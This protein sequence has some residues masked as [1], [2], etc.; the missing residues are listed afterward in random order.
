MSLYRVIITI[1]L[2]CVFI[3][4][5][6]QNYQL[7]KVTKAELEQKVHPKDSSAAAAILF[8]KG[9]TYFSYNKDAGFTANHVCEVKIKIYKKEGL[10]WAN[11]KV[12]F[13]IGYEKLNSD[14]LDF[15]DAV[16]YNLENGSIV[17]TKLENQGTFKNKINNYWKEKTITLPNVKVG[18][19]IEYRYVLKSENIVKFPDFDIQ[20]DIPVDYFYYKTELP[21]YYVYKPILVGYIHVDAEAKMVN[22]SQTYDN[23]YGQTAGFTYKQIDSFYSGK[24]IPALKQEPFVDNME[25]YRGCIKHELERVRYPEQPVKD[26]AMTWEG[27][28][29]TI[30]KDEKFAKEFKDTK[31]L[32]DD[33]NRLLANV[34]SPNE[35]LKIIFGYVQ[36]RMNWNEICDY[37]PEKGVV[38]AYIDQTGNVAE[39]NFILIDMLRLAGIETNPVLVSTIENG[40]PVYPTR[41]GFNYVIA[42][43]E[44]DGKQILLDASHKFTSPN[45]LPLNVL[46]WKGRLIKNDGTSQE[47]NL[48][49]PNQSKEIFNLLAKIDGAGKIDGQLRIQRSDYDA[50]HFRVE[51]NTKT[52]DKYLE[53]IEEQLGNLSISNYKI[54]NQ[55][56]NI[57]DPIVETFDFTSNG[58]LEIIGGKIFVN[59]LLFF[60]RRKNPFNQEERKMPLYFGYKNAERFNLNIQIPEGY[61]IESMPKPVKISSEDKQIVYTLNCSVD[62]DKVQIISTKEINNSIFA[63]EG[64][65]MLKDFFQKI[66]VN[67]NQKIVLKKK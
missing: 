39:I 22:G 1:L 54:E 17:K 52:Q 3:K 33:I 7:G 24:D 8:K 60:T 36:N 66:I 38:K 34:E 63:A 5:E 44:I 20:Y 15:S 25:N 21:E 53:K 42:A 28:A 32:V 49:P 40:L 65:E 47:I 41:T 31:F 37:Y 16:T 23:Q 67:Q 12:K 4:S 19:I 61:E 27:V 62:G 58:Q 6:A 13:Y 48:D 64:Y 50:Y 57:K 11:Q 46:N 45:I 55:K 43:A 9:R 59:P 2:V 29:S 14:Q 30:F 56:A 35:R 26:Y 51:N 18:S 10:N